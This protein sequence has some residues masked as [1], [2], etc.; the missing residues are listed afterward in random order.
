MLAP[1]IVCKLKKYGISYKTHDYF[2]SYLYIRQQN[3]DINSKISTFETINTSVIQGRILGP[4]IF[5]ISV[6]ELYIESNLFRK[7]F[8]DDTGRIEC[9][10]TLDTLLN[11]VNSEISKNIARSFR[12]EKRQ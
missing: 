1:I 8:A 4:I 12:G 6:N 5:F 3:V 7:M 9:N 2:A 11:F 10:P